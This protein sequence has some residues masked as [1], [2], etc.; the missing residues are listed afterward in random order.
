M[1][2]YLALLLI[3][4]ALQSCY[5]PVKKDYGIYSKSLV[6]SKDQKWLINTIRTGVDSHHREMMDKE[7]LKLFN[8][9][10]NGQAYTL[11]MAK[12]QN[13]IQDNIPFQPENEDLETLKNTSD[14]NFLVNISTIKV[15]NDLDTSG[16][17]EQFTYQ[18]NET[19]AIMD[20]YD[21]RTMKKVYSF[22]ASSL[23]SVEKGEKVT[24]FTPTSEMMTMKNFRSLLKSIKK[25]AVKS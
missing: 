17:G 6:F 7:T 10:S 5:Y 11:Q 20:V 3:L 13:I 9:L 23:V 21:I 15:R 25:N 2:K 4:F 12:S 24:I 22:K 18:R 14:F 1:K 8:E 16:A 19:S